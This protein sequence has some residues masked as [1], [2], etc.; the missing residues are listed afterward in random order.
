MPTVGPVQ[1]EDFL[2]QANSAFQAGLVGEAERLCQVVLSSQPN[3][4]E[5][6]LLMADL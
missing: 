5:A 1:P 2:R 4:L 3:N 6:A